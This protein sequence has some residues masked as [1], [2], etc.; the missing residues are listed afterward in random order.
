MAAHANRT[1]A[2]KFSQQSARFDQAD[3]KNRSNSVSTSRAVREEPS[4]QMPTSTSIVNSPPVRKR[5][6]RVPHR[7]GR[8]T[9]LLRSARP[10]FSS[11]ASPP[12]SLNIHAD[13][14]DFIR[15]QHL[16]ASFRWIVQALEIP[17]TDRRTVNLSPKGEPQLGRHGLSFRY[18]DQQ[19]SGTLGV[20]PL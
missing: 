6:S 5:Q 17:Q 9:E 18:L 4:W 10:G 12:S 16:A 19:H 11:A 8:A 14:L 7:L 13:N 15:P 1:N 3:Q 2:L 20:Q